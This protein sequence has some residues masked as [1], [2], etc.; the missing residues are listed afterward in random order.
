MSPR[1]HSGPCI[2]CPVCGLCYA[3]A[4]ESGLS[5]L[6]EESAEVRYRADVIVER[7]QDDRRRAGVKP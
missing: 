2:P 6:C 1:L 4:A 3:C 5:C 7:R